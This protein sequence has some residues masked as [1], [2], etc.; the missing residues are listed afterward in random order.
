MKIIDRRRIGPLLLLMSFAV[1]GSLTLML[2]F[3]SFGGETS[4]ARAQDSCIEN[5]AI[6]ALLGQLSC[7]DATAT[8]E[9]Q[10]GNGGGGDAEC[11]ENPA[12]AALLGQTSCADLTATAV[13][14]MTATAEANAA[15]TAQ[16]QAALT[17]TAEAIAAATAQAEADMTATAIAN[18]AATAQARAE[19]TATAQAQMTATA[20][21]KMT[22]TAVAQATVTS[23]GVPPPQPKATATPVMAET[24]E[25][26]GVEGATAVDPDAQVSL[27]AG[28]VTVKFPTLSRARSFQAMVSES[29]DCGDMAMA[30]AMVTMYNAEGEMESDVRLISSAEIEVM[31]SATM[32]DELG[33]DLDGGAVAIQANALGGVMLQIMD[34]ESG[35]WNSIPSS[36]MVNADGSVTVS[37]MTRGLGAVALNVYP[38]VVEKARMQVSMALGTPTA[39]PIPPTATPTPVPPPPTGDIASAPFLMLLVMAVAAAMLAL[40]GTKVIMARVRR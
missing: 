35:E 6:A 1:I 30:C 19:R 38:D 36:F 39:T 3:S 14:N 8:A 31:L 34:E 18:A 25:V 9:A 21:A 12:I 10:G 20:S 40:V 2:A 11:V 22:A 4:T 28:N 23:G 13:A 17:A 29:S 5:P 16:A 15:A 27:M 32:V 33:G 7:A 26:S 24:V 37:G